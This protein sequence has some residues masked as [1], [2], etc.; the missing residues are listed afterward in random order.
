MRR[1]VGALGFARRVVALCLDGAINGQTRECTS[2]N[3]RL[4]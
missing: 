2:S 1:K 3:W 4:V